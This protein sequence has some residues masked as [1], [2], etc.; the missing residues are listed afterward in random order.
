VEVKDDVWESALPLHLVGSQGSNSGLSG[1]AISSFTGFVTV[2]KE[3]TVT[4][5]LLCL[6]GISSR[7]MRKF[8]AANNT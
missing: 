2:I 6:V 1:L 8:L 3:R 4:T 7:G 5:R